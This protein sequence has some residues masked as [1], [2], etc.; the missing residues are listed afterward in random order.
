MEISDGESEDGQMAKFEQEEKAERLSNKPA[1]TG[2]QPITKEDLEKCR[3]SRDQLLKFALTPW[4]EDYVKGSLS[5][6]LYYIPNSWIC[7]RMGA[8]LGR[9]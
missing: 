6:S 8:I 2:S 5:Q 7:R 9:K 1:S 3:L 4:F